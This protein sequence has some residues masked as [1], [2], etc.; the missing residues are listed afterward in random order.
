MRVKFLVDR[1]TKNGPSE[2]GYPEGDK[3]KAG[4]VYELPEPSAQHWINR[5]AAE[6]TTEPV[7]KAK[8]EA[9]PESKVETVSVK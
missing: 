2:G 9:K 1:V 4:C 6:E 3:F 7:T 5:R 8:S